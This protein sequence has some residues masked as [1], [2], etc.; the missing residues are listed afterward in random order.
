MVLYQEGFEV[1]RLR[2]HFKNKNKNKKMKNGYSCCLRVKAGN[3]H[4]YPQHINCILF[5]K[6]QI[7]LSICVFTFYG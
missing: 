2:P 5:C 3:A 6:T 7:F 4:S 1:D